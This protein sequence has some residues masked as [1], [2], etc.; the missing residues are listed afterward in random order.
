M[1]N[2]EDQEN[3]L[4]RLARCSE[5][6]REDEYNVLL[7][8]SADLSVLYLLNAHRAL[9]ATKGRGYAEEHPELVSALIQAM[10]INLNT[11]ARIYPVSGKAII[12]ALVQAREAL[13]DG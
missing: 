12:Q 10:A 9:D 1:D 13:E 3:I 11:I 6:D 4:A 8:A 2:D 5:E 7:R